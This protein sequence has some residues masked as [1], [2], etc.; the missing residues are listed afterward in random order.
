MT[1]TPNRAAQLI[2][3]V[4]TT[5]FGTALVVVS[6][7]GQAITPDLAFEWNCA[8]GVAAV[9]TGCALAWSVGVAVV[10]PYEAVRDRRRQPRDGQ[11]G[12]RPKAVPGSTR[13]MPDLRDAALREYADEQ[14]W[15]VMADDWTKGEPHGRHAAR[16]AWEMA[17]AAA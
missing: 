6:V 2:G 17:E 4:V 9:V 15:R 14:P 16:P 10:W 3:G 12:G 5:M 13:P 1:T 8:A 7:F 11:S